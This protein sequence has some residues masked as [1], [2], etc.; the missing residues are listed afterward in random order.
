MTPAQEFAALRRVT[1]EEALQSLRDRGL[2]TQTFSWLDLWQAEH[3]FQFTVS[4]LAN[5]DLLA[6][7]LALIT[8]SVAGDL[9][10]TDFLRDA[11]TALQS[12][13]W[14]GTKEVVNPA[15]GEI[16]RTRFNAQRLQLIY[17]TNT[18]HA[19]ATGQW[20][21]IQSTRES[22]PYLRYITQRDERV[23]A[24][25]AAWDNVTLPVGHSWWL[26][27]Y[28]PNGWRCR[29]RVVQVNQRE[30]DRGTTPAGGTMNKTAPTVVLRDW[31]D[32]NTGQVRQIPA[33]VDPGFGFNP[34]QAR[35]DAQAT[36]WTSKLAGL[37][38]QLG[39]VLRQQ[40]PNDPA[41]TGPL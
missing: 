20:E 38:P 5:A 33:G 16:L 29:C 24:S 32:R 11:K 26:T 21:R 1:P 19:Y 7:L 14:W 3:S 12:K 28:P 35:R 22:H 10:R 4:R 36:L 15:T 23:R 9:T 37:P 18:R 31:L 40:G 34:G 8:D 27:H 25:H 6:D 39:Q 41:N 17:D 30:F 2:I 13:G